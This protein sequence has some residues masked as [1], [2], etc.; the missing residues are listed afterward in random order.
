MPCVT[1]REHFGQVMAAGIVLGLKWALRHSSEQKSLPLCTGKAW[2]CVQYL[3]RGGAGGR[4]FPLLV[5]TIFRSAHAF[6]QV[7]RFSKLPFCSSLRLMSWFPHIGQ[8]LSLISHP[9]LSP[10][11]VL[12]AYSCYFSFLKMYI[13]LPARF[14]KPSPSLSYIPPC[15]MTGTTTTYRKL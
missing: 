12:R 1:I 2:Q 14:A 3:I 4:D 5:C 9:P 13:T 6:E 11:R 7:A 8:Y 15:P 10:S